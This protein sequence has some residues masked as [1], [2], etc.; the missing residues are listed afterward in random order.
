MMLLPALLSLV[1]PVPDVGLMLPAV[2]TTA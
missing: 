2:S 1:Q